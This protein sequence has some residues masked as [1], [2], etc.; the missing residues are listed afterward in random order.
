MYELLLKDIIKIFN[1]SSL[2]NG[3]YEVKCGCD[4]LWVQ[5]LTLGLSNFM[6]AANWENYGIFCGGNE[7][8][9]NN[10]LQ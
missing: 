6:W 1:V 3:E 10:I 9:S 8:E 5:L 2:K 4:S 7:Y